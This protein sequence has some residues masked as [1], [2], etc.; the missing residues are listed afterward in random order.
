MI[1]SRGINGYERVP[2]TTANRATTTTTPKKYAI[3]MKNPTTCTIILF[4]V[5]RTNVRLPENQWVQCAAVVLE[6]CLNPR[7]HLPAR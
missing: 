3:Y 1:V 6:I 7:R 5:P 4:T 2:P